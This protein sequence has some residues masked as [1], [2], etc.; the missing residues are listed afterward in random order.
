M[1]STG[2]QVRY[3]HDTVSN[4]TNNRNR[5]E[6]NSSR[7]AGS[8]PRGKRAATIRPAHGMSHSHS[9]L[10]NHG[11]SHGHYVHH[12]ASS[13]PQHSRSQ[14]TPISMLVSKIRV[15]SSS[16]DVGGLRLRQYG[17][18]DALLDDHYYGSN[19]SGSGT[20]VDLDHEMQLERKLAT[21]YKTA[22]QIA[23]SKFGLYPV[24]RSDTPSSGG[25]NGVGSSRSSNGGGA[26]A[27][28]V[29]SVQFN[30]IG[31]RS[32]RTSRQAVNPYMRSPRTGT[33]VGTVST[34]RQQGPLGACVVVE[35][36]KSKSAKGKRRRRHRHQ[37]PA[38]SPVSEEAQPGDALMSR[39]QWRTHPI[40]DSTYGSG[41]NS[42]L[43]SA[44][45]ANGRHHT[46]HTTYADGQFSPLRTDTDLK[47]LRDQ[48]AAANRT[49][50]A[51]LKEWQ[52]ELYTEMLA[53]SIVSSATEAAVNEAV[54]W[55][56][57]TKE[58]EEARQE[59]AARRKVLAE[60]ARVVE[61]AA[62][63]ARKAQEED[64]HRKTEQLATEL[65]RRRRSSLFHHALDPVTMNI[66]AR[67]KGRGW[68]ARAFDSVQR[69]KQKVRDARILARM[70]E[71]DA[72][73]EAMDQE[74]MRRELENDRDGSKA[75]AYRG[76]GKRISHLFP[77]DLVP[78]TAADKLKALEDEKLA[79]EK[80]RAEMVRRL[81]NL[82][83]ACD[84][85]AAVTARHREPR[86]SGS[87]EAGS[88][89]IGGSGGG[90]NNNLS[91]QQ[92]QQQQQHSHSGRHKSAHGH[93]LKGRELGTTQ[94]PKLEPARLSQVL[95]VHRTFDPVTG[96]SLQGMY[97]YP[98][99]SGMSMSLAEEEYLLIAKSRIDGMAEHERIA[100]NLG[101]KRPHVLLI[102]SKWQI[103]DEHE[104][105]FVSMARFKAAARQHDEDGNPVIVVNYNWGIS[106]DQLLGKICSALQ[107]VAEQCGVPG[108]SVHALSIGMMVHHS[109]GSLFMTKEQ[110]TSVTTLALEDD[111]ESLHAQQFWQRLDGVLSGAGPRTFAAPRGES[112]GDRSELEVNLLGHGLF[113]TEQGQGLAVMLETMLQCTVQEAILPYGRKLVE[114][115]F[116]WDQFVAAHEGYK[117]EKRANRIGYDENEDL[118]IAAKFRRQSNDPK[119][120]QNVRSRRRGSGRGG[121]VGGVGG[122]GAG[123][124]PSTK[125]Q[126]VNPT[127]SSFADAWQDQQEHL[128]IGGSSSNAHPRPRRDTLEMQK[129]MLPMIGG[130]GQVGT[131]AKHRILP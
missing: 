95:E 82:R 69:R 66:S 1:P 28:N 113:H 92:Q 13:T 131:I 27:L 89:N 25:G 40:Y 47:F 120:N 33:G 31:N 76:T 90:G 101:F 15:P 57:A 102:S 96:F 87:S 60:E 75:R 112:I 2:G 26:T 36:A 104:M 54:S 50:R 14:S 99:G 72:E 94:P 4:E 3:L 125:R 93:E 121:A 16:E 97:T 70:A 59:L 123:K 8:G 126:P 128:H 80:I 81:R 41:S 35:P 37:R 118:L 65:R 115:Y 68:R 98:L 21:Q 91:D 71:I 100:H 110:L 63:A 45:S 103:S 88:N 18:P 46:G 48:D 86:A 73:L 62:I 117:M 79:R 53:S 11:Q 106:P 105:S 64:D 114:K 129:G 74:R 55:M 43:G 77:D 78:S 22:L 107:A 42:G 17:D 119:R 83:A 52:V 108:T 84:L 61:G 130:G 32:R 44:A 67:I 38:T 7:A 56:A 58:E 116:H 39:S 109:H 23:D 5:H 29:T 122:R 10:Q 124:G 85:K 30:Q 6:C 34:R 51:A 49:R 20:V 19:S 9:H 24:E 127:P 12:G 111:E